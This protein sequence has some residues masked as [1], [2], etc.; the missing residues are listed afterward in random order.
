MEDQLLL[1]WQLPQL[2]AN[3][4]TT[5]TQAYSQAQPCSE[6]DVYTLCCQEALTE[7]GKE[8]SRLP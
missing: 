6:A 8:Q 2:K 7:M 3:Q 4:P 5:F 1:F